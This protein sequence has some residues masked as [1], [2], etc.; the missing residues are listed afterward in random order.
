MDPLANHRQQEIM[1][2]LRRAG[3]SLRVGAIAS[4]LNVTSET[5]RR[6]LRSL[7]EGGLVEKMHGGVRLNVADQ[8]QE[9]QEESLTGRH[10][11]WTSA[12]PRPISPMRCANGI[13]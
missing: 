4:E 1:D 7:V 2:A 10:C 5:V 8:D 12:A 6:N 11:F 9:Q 13:A 3:G